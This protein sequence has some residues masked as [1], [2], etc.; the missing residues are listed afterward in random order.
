MVTTHQDWL[1]AQV[2]VL[3]SVLIDPSLASKIVSETK[4][5]DY[6]GHFRTIYKTICRLFMAGKPADPVMINDA[7]GGAYSEVLLQMMELTPSPAA[8]DYYIG[9]C[10]K[11]GRLLQLRDLGVQLQEAQDMD[12]MAAILELANSV[13]AQRS[14]YKPV[15]MEEAL[16]RFFDR[17]DKPREYLSWPIDGLDGRL[18]A[19][20]GDF[21]V[22]AGYPSDGKSA[23]AMQCAYH[24]ARNKRVGIFSLETNPDKLTDRMVAYSARL[25]LPRIKTG[26][27]TEPEWEHVSRHSSEIISHQLEFVPAAGISVAEIRAVSL[28]NR[29]DV[30]FVDYIQLVKGNRRDR[31]SEVTGIST[32]WLSLQELLL[33]VCRSSTV[34]RFAKMGAMLRLVSQ[35]FANP[36]RLSRMLILYLWFIARIQIVM[37]VC[38]WC[39]KT[40]RASV[41]A[42]SWTLMDSTRLSQGAA[43]IN[44]GRSRSRYASQGSNPLLPN[45][46]YVPESFL[47]EVQNAAG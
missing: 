3:G 12:E 30:I 10:L 45:D 25:P 17:R 4:E 9:A 38:C 42:W 24:L 41:A 36:A 27:M 35:I 21:I 7:L 11:K 2:G 20:Q 44:T 33:L 5:D 18:F 22:I 29:Y 46:T 26:A 16:A 47:T 15:T 1:D 31:Y 39:A 32:Q 8:V 14:R 37:S 6:T 23:L 43:G 40:R 13:S 19:E 28:A 34:L